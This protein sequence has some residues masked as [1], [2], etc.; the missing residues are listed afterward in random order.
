MP[1]ISFVHTLVMDSS[2]TFVV[3]LPSGSQSNEAPEEVSE[4]ASQEVLPT[5]SGDLTPVVFVP[6]D[7]LPNCK[8]DFPVDILN[9]THFD[10][11]YYKP[12]ASD[13]NGYYEFI[14]PEKPDQKLTLYQSGLRSVVKNLPLAITA[15]KS[16]ETNFNLQN[17]SNTYEVGVINTF[18]GMSTRLVVNTYQGEIFI[19]LK[20][21]TANQRGE[22]FP[23]RK[24]VQ[25]STKDDVNSIAAFIKGKK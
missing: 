25:F 7:S 24:S 13:A 16:L 12:T 9:L 17:D 5:S 2:A 22:I 20:L 15:A 6:F 3:S 14:S 11:A 23:T 21:F 18:N 10:L 8:R 19:Y 4:E 1:F